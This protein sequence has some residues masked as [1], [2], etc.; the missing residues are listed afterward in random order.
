MKRNV[1]VHPQSKVKAVEE[2]ELG[3][4]HVHHNTLPVK[5]KANEVVID[6]L[7]EYLHVRKSKILII[8][9]QHSRKKVIETF[10]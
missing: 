1:F 7:S 4:I 6:M 5:G 9:G 10:E 8:S 2:D 3:L